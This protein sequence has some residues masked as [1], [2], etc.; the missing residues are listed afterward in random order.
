MRTHPFLTPSRIIAPVHAKFSVVVCNSRIRLV[1]SYQS[2]VTSLAQRTKFT[3]FPRLSRLDGQ[4]SNVISSFCYTCKLIRNNL[5]VPKHQS[6]WFCR[7][8]KDLVSTLQTQQISKA[9]T[10]PMIWHQPIPTQSMCLY[11]Y[12]YIA[13]FWSKRMITVITKTCWS[14]LM[15]QHHLVINSHQFKRSIFGLAVT[16]SVDFAPS[17]SCRHRTPRTS[18]SSFFE[19]AIWANTFDPL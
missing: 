2:K 3:T 7:I 8:R 15:V 18:P 16:C 11:N 13:S 12:M 17:T 10:N 4:N 9:W 14:I 6:T 19:N 1:S 5:W